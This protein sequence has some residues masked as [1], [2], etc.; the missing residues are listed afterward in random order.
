MESWQ[1]E[2]LLNRYFAYKRG[3]TRVFDVGDVPN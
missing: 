1:K 2:F 3:N